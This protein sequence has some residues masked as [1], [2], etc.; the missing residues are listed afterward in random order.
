MSDVW[1]F[2]AMD[3]SSGFVRSTVYLLVFI[4]EGDLLD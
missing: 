2:R 1:G 4:L 3:K